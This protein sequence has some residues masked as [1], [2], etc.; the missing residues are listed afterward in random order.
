M[1]NLRTSD[2][3]F[4]RLNIMMNIHSGNFSRGLLLVLLISISG[5]EL[6][7]PP[8]PF[9]L[10]DI[11]DIRYTEHVQPLIF[12]KYCTNCHAGTNAEA[13]LRLDSW[14]N[15]MSGSDH[16]EAVIPFDDDNSLMVRMLTTLEGGPHPGELG[17]DTLLQVELD[18]LRRWVDLGA[19]F[20][21]PI[22]AAIANQGVVPFSEP[23]RELLFVPNQEDGLI[24]V[25]DV[26][27][28]L[29]IRT[30]DL[31]NDPND[32]NITF[33]PNTRPH[34]VEV[35]PDASAIYVSLIGD[36]A[37]LKIS[38]DNEDIGGDIDGIATF[39]TPGMLALNPISNQLFV[40][41][42]L[43][44]VSPP[45]SIGKIN[46]DDMS[47][48]EIELIAQR[49][50]ALAVDPSGDFVHT[51]SLSENRIYTINTTNDE[52]IFTLLQA[53]FSAF[54]HFGASPDGTR[55]AASGQQ[56]N[57]VMILDTS[58]PPGIS[59]IGSIEVGNAPWHPVWTPDSRWV[60]VGN[61]T[62]NTVSVIDADNFTVAQTISGEGLAEPHGSA[63]TSD[64]SY[65][66]IS[67]RNT[68]GTYVP[69]YNLGN[70]QNTGTV[71][72]INTA[73]NEIDKVIEV[74]RF[75]AGLST[76]VQ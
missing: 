27:A 38:L 58:A 32:L 16:G 57:Q 56:S 39:E 36:N 41:R 52:A 76:V 68:S 28:K 33:S 59:R 30:I 49:P 18:F 54:I 51:A 24:S 65:V 67:N 15:V 21:G 71:V 55:L 17:A 43:S 50:H 34:D 31:I 14:D 7:T 53:P 9:R 42:S 29:V 60:Y 63:I 35:E 45:R 75:P 19:R 4:L 74:G 62:D 48:S 1:L 66:F 47:I 37:V 72:V 64:G 69:R 22:D 11:E 44:A 61:M 2:V 23:N 25:V 26:N 5:C 73:T 20:D 8:D 6:T 3:R 10:R 12:D 13:G 40:G 46:T 70:N